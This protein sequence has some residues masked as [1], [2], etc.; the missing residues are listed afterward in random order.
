EGVVAGGQLPADRS[1]R[2]RHAGRGRAGRGPV[3]ERLVGAAG[4]VP[5][6]GRAGRAPL[7]RSVDGGGAGDWSGARHRVPRPAASGDEREAVRR[8]GLDGLN[9][10]AVINVDQCGRT[11]SVYSDDEATI[12]QRDGRTEVIRHRDDDGR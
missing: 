10:A 7:A 3:A 4:R 11:T 8:A 2:A 9:A 6:T 5:A 12:V 1:P